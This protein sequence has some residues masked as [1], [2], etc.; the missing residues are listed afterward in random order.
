MHGRL[1][2]LFHTAR[3]L[4]LQQV[5]GQVRRRIATTSPL[6][7]PGKGDCAPAYPGCR[8]SHPKNFLAP[9]TQGLAADEIRR[10]RFRFLNISQKTGFPPRWDCDNPSRLW[11][12]N[13]HYFDWLWVLDYGSGR[14]VVLDWIRGYAGGAG[15]VGW[16]PYPVSLRI[17]NWCGYFFGRFPDR[18]Q[19]DREFCLA[20]WDSVY[21]QCTWLSTHLETQL[22]NNHYLENAAALVFAGG[23]FYGRQ[24]DRWLNKGLP[25]LTKQVSEQVLSDGMHFEL[26]PMYHCRILY[27]LVL[28]MG[29]DIP[30]VKELLA[31]PV[32]RMARA[33][34]RLCHPDGRIALLS[35]SAMDV[36]HEPGDLLSYIRR[37]WP[38][39]SPPED[40]YACF[41]LPDSGYYGWQGT[42]GTYVIADYGRIG[43]DHCPGHGHADIFSFELSVKG[44]RM[45]VDTGVHDYE[46]SDARNYC[47]S[48]AAHNTVEVEG[49]DQCELWGAFRVARRG[50]PRDITW[51]AGENGFTLS[52]RHDGYRRLPGAPE[53]SRRMD[54]D[55]D[56]GL[57]V[58]DRITSTRPVHCVS[59]LHLHPDCRVTDLHGRAVE[60]ACPDANLR[61]EGDSEITV[62]ETPYFE[63][64]YETQSRSSLCMH[65]E[66]TRAEMRY[67]IRIH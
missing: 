57:A 17:M 14:Q 18:T 33:L 6:S 30:A 23:C 47:R 26:S 52:G 32:Y 11:Q 60:I 36:Y 12:Y 41:A 49:Q 15:R 16:E 31:E 56:R 65:G 39:L 61:V 24:A 62:E 37:R 54:W 63:R 13:L 53:H 25:I 21:R 2:R 22:L 48:T 43:P 1:T 59:R 42:D 27:V 10:G 58:H 64:F 44:R 38:S 7:F 5:Y 9:A 45:I 67:S 29:T 3:H 34:Q 40:Q 55:A 50:Y 8:W 20:L 51:C 4:R 19:S 66:G 28:L 35:D 46:P